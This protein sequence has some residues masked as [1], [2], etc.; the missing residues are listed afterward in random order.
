MDLISVAVTI[1]KPFPIGQWSK[2]V[3][4]SDDEK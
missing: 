1:P 3:F 2:I 4:L